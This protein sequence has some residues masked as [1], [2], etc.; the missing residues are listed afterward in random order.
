MSTAVSLPA[1][2]AKHETAQ[3]ALDG[4]AVLFV[5]ESHALPIVSIVVSLR[6]GSSFDPPGMDGLARVVGRMLRRGCE[7]MDAHAIEDAVDQLGG[8]VSLDVS[9]SSLA[10]HT[11]V[12]ERNVD[13]FVDLVAKLIAKPTFP[14]DELARLLRE[15]SAEIVEGRDNDRSLAQH[16]FRRKLFGDHAYG[17]SSQGTVSGVEA[18]TADAVRAFYTKHFVQGNVVVG[19]AGDI[20]VERARELTVRL[21]AGLPKG[22]PIGDGVGAPT[23]TPGRRLVIV[24][25]PER[26][27]TQIL[28][29]CLGTAPHDDDHVALGVA[30]AVFGGTFTSRLMREVRSKRGWSYGA[31]ARLALDRQR[32]SFSMW[33]FPAAT[34]APACI[35]LELELLET[36]IA[37]GITPKEAAFIKRYLAR[38]QA[39]EVDTASKRLH[40][41]LD[42]ELLGLPKDYHSSYVEKV[43]ATTLEE[44]NAAAKARIDAENVLIV[45]VGTAS[46]I[47]AGLKEAIPRL[48]STEIVAFDSE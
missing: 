44:A 21:L 7:G 1:K 31:Y 25:K 40:Q 9:A 48:T 19:F 23:A 46:Q 28:I 26:S 39:F 34:D 35:K 13:A 20:T 17:R 42:I 38:S 36:F 14:G 24:D 29:G 4:G 3:I 5:E 41:A 22:G 6:S 33:T 27:Q 12:I 32:Q 15:T 8:E 43:N 11:Q 2:K 37:N 18:V 47:E 10:L 30:N 16:F 45:V